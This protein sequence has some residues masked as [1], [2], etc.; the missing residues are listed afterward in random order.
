MPEPVLEPYEFR[1]GN[2]GDSPAVN[3][4]HD[5]APRANPSPAYGMLPPFRGPH[6]ASD[7][8][9]GGVVGRDRSVR[10]AVSRGRTDHRSASCDPGAEELP[11]QPRGCQETPGSGILNAGGDDTMGLGVSYDFGGARPRG[12]ELSLDEPLQPEEVA[13]AASLPPETAP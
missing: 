9:P 10:G 3:G 1:P 7:P 6:R 12:A 13:R 2:E 11:G 8:A 4:Q 5:P